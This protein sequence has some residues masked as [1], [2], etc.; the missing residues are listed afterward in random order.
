MEHVFFRTEKNVTYHTEKNGVPN[1]EHM[2]P[3]STRGCVT[4]ATR[5]AA[6]VVGVTL[7][8]TATGLLAKEGAARLPII[9]PSEEDHLPDLHKDWINDSFNIF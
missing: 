6:A 8:L 3:L 1:P 2:R 7:A 9:L 5:S 4:T